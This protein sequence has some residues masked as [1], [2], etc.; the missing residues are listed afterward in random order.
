M[1][2]AMRDMIGNI[3]LQEQRAHQR[4]FGRMFDL[5][6]FRE[7]LREY[8]LEKMK[9]L[10]ELGLEF[11]F[12]PFVH[13]EYGASFPGWKK[14]P[15]RWYYEQMRHGT[16]VR[17]QSDGDPYV[18]RAAETLEG[19]TVLIDTRLKPPYK[20]GKQV[21][22]KDNLLGPIIERLRRGGKIARYN[23]SPQSSRFNVLSQGWILHIRPALAR[24]LEVDIGQVRLERAIEANV[25]PQLYPR[26]ARGSDGETNSWMWYEER[27]QGTARQL[28]HFA[29]GSSDYGGLAGI[30]WGGDGWRRAAFRPLVVLG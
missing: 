6:G 5:V 12:L 15:A 10:G 28:G 18:D 21:F 13:M 16:V 25:I 30:A 20:D 3:V 11:H 29:G 26:M 2:K 9:W 4:F 8:T 7:I 24:M 22:R 23:P 14:K 27:F 1:D 17:Y 19:R